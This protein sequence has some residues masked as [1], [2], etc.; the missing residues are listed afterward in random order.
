MIKFVEFKSA[1]TKK[2]ISFNVSYIV[3]VSERETCTDICIGSLVGDKHYIA[4][5]VTSVEESYDE[6]MRQI[7]I[8]SEYKKYVKHK[9]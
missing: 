3:D 6:V 9:V 4:P 1:I 2:R 7:W 5:S 8:V